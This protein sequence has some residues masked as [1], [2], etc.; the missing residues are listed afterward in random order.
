M[1]ITITPNFDASYSDVHIETDNASVR[2]ARISR[3]MAY[4]LIA[5]LLQNN[6]TTTEQIEAILQECFFQKARRDE[7][8]K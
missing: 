7:E 3:V 2:V 4:S 6:P 8:A 5:L 1:K